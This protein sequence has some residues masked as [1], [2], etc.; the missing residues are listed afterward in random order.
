VFKQLLTAFYLSLLLSSIASAQ[1]FDDIKNT[2]LPDRVGYVNDFS[3]IFPEK[4]RQALETKLKKY[5]QATGR[6]FLV[7]SFPALGCI[8]EEDMC[9]SVFYEKWK[10]RKARKD[11]HAIML[12]LSGANRR[13]TRSFLGF[14]HGEDR[15]LLE[16]AG[17]DQFVVN[18]VDRL[19]AQGKVSEA[20]VAYINFITQTLSAPIK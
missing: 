4:T 12:F 3:E 18:T 5:E 9:S 17:H 7:V 16:Q 20:N 8:F 15:D 1:M 14:S 2:K 11:H 19:I 10:I 6:M 13:G